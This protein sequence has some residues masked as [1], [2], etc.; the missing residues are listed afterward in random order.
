VSKIVSIIRKSTPPSINAQGDVAVAGIV[1]IR[2]DRGGAVGRAEDAGNKTRAARFRRLR[3]RAFSRE[4]RRGEV[5]FRDHRLHAV[6]AHRW[7][8]RI[9]G[10]RLDDVRAGL[11]ELRVDIADDRGSRDGQQVV[12]ALEI[13][14]PVS[15]ALASI[16]VFTEPVALDH[17]AHRTVEQDDAVVERLEQGLDSL[18][19]VH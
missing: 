5:Q 8:I 2:R 13:A 7:R 11:E 6:V 4:P 1:D 16:I 15:E 10:I 3:V 19:P 14:A 9:E 18:F 17:R 12:V